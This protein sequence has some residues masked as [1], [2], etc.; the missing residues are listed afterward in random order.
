MNKKS[1]K[2]IVKEEFTFTTL[3]ITTIAILIAMYILLDNLI[4]TETV[5]YSL[6][7]IALA[8]AG[9]EFGP[10]K[11]GLVAVLGDIVSALIFGGFPIPLVLLS[12]FLKGFA[13][14]LILYR[15]RTIPFIVIVAAVEQLILSWF[16]T[17]L[18][19]HFYYGM[20]YKALVVARVAQVV[21]LFFVE[22]VVI[23][24]LVKL[25]YKPL[26]DIV[27]GKKKTKT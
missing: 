6:A 11:A 23:F 1:F 12:N 15:K 19:L 7:F 16:L 8:V 24:A 21:P 17:P 20:P 2:E 27:S 5:K 13:H 22:I 25:L 26:K 3:Q 9:M 4:H 18:G 10:T 14:G